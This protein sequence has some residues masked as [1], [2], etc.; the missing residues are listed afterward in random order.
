MP[1]LPTLPPKDKYCRKH[2]R[3][4][5]SYIC[6]ECSEELNRKEREHQTSLSNKAKIDSQLQ[7]LWNG[8]FIVKEEEY[9]ILFICPICRE[10][11]MYF[12]KLTKVRE[13]LNKKCSTLR[14]E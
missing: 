13:C 5:H 3:T 1:Y 10:H 6:P 4:Y 9:Y 14:G 12:N 2:S 7:A 11:S 8:D